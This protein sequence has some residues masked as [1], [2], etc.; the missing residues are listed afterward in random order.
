MDAIGNK[1]S[2]ISY[3]DSVREQTHGYLD[4]LSDEDLRNVPGHMG[5]PFN[6]SPVREFFAMTIHHQNYHFG[7]LY[8]IAQMN[9]IDVN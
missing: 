5:E 4:A 8:Q 2:I 6:N 9:G 7:Q 1:A 3:W